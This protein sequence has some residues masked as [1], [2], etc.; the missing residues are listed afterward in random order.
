MSLAAGFV[1][2]VFF[3]AAPDQYNTTLFAAATPCFIAT[4]H[5]HSTTTRNPR[6]ARFSQV[7]LKLLSIFRIGDITGDY[8]FSMHDCRLAR[9]L[10]RGIRPQYR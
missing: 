10:S 3:R 2:A 6:L 4:Q 9:S 7:S 5:P 1:P 8:L